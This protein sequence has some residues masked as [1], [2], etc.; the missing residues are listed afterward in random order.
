MP[1]YINPNNHPVH[2]TGPNGEMIKVASRQKVVL[3]E[4]YDRYRKR[5]FI[6]L[7]SGIQ[8][9]ENSQQH[10]KLQAQVR[11]RI[12][13]NRRRR[14]EQE[15]SKLREI[16]PDQNDRRQGRIRAIHAE[17]ERLRQEVAKKKQSITNSRRL[18][19]KVLTSDGSQILEPNLSIGYPISNNIGVGILSYNRKSSLERLVKSIKKYTNLMKTTI[20]ISD[21]CSDNQELA[22][23]LDEL[24]DSNEFVI[25]RNSE[26]LGV[27]G[28]TNRLLDCLSRFK[29]GIL[30]NDDIEVKR[31]GWDSFYFKAMQQSMMH[32]FIYRQQGVYGA[33]RGNKV[34]I[35]GVECLYCDDKPHGSILAYTNDAFREIGY[36]DES[37]GMYGMEHVDWSRRIFETGMQRPGYY[38]VI[39][40][41]LYFTIHNEASAMDDRV[42]KLRMA[43]DVYNRK[44][45]NKAATYW[46]DKSDKVTVPYISYVVPFRNIDRTGAIETIIH[47]IRSQRFPKIEIIMV[48]HDTAK[49]VDENKLVPVRYEHINSEGRLF[50]KSMAFNLGVSKVASDS[51]I[52]QD[53]DILLRADYTNQ[54]YNILKHYHSCHIG[55]HVVYAD[56]LTSSNIINNQQVLGDLVLNRVVGYFEG[57]SLACRTSEYWKCGAFNEDY[58]GY[59]CEDCDFYARLAAD[60]CG[61]YGIRTADF[62]HLHHGRV[63]GW[64]QHHKT[65]KAIEQALNSKTICER[66]KLQYAQLDRLG[67]YEHIKDFVA[68]LA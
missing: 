19:G 8:H 61:Y 38:D 59:G 44:Y 27:A 57:G 65:N 46:V 41:E 49:K 21:D 39:G 47:N 35:N 34:V 40:S 5:G 4:Y 63:D 14:K 43:R 36:F 11:L 22:L 6:K 17:K 7:V 52:L 13:E 33:E 26:R 60:P 55:K 66:I 56:Q 3:S 23:Y 53:A 18:V 62:L 15:D 45:E 54:I 29:Y 16:T 20:F 32:H 37:F 51:V 68:R 10:E 31:E 30:L 1:E 24:E 2:L 25:L 64:D 67:Y 50:N 42:A 9:K 58:W 12:E 28:N 48:E